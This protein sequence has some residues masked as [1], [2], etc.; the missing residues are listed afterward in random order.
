MKLLGWNCRGLGNPRAVRVLSDLLKARNPDFVFLSETISDA[1]RIENLRVKFGFS[2][3]FSVDRVGRSGGLAIFW[4]RHVDC[5]FLSY[6]Q[7]HVD[8]VFKIN[9]MHD[10]RMSCFYGFPERSRRSAS[11]DFIRMLANKSPLPWCIFGDF[12]DLLSVTD[13]EG[14]IPHPSSL[15]DGFR[16][17]IDDCSLTEL[18]LEGGKFTWE[19]GRGT[20]DWVRE[21]LDRAFA[22]YSWW[23]KF[24]LCNLSTWHVT[25]SDHD[26]IM[27]DLYNVPR[28]I[29]KFRFKFENVWLE[30]ASFRKEVTDYWLDLPPVHILPKL[31]SVSSFMAK[32]GKN[33]FHKFR[34]KVRKQKEELA[35]LVDRTDEM[36]VRQY[37]L[38]RD[39]L[40]ELLLN[41]EVYWKQRAKS[42]WL[43]EGDD[44]TKFFHAT[45]SARRKTN[46]ITH[47][48]TEDGQRVENQE[49]MCKIVHEYF[50]RIF[51][52]SQ[53]D[54]TG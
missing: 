24:P 5:E 54:D 50:T 3:C 17:V 33:F 36:G 7:N 2:Q 20:S 10:W 13:K 40:N 9:N 51:T 21:K 44:N 1:S 35:D 16:G 38:A 49:D 47:L 34:D 53:S 52:G 8:V 29:R 6:S 42:F 22:E 25:Y 23:Q 19:R 12:N 28:S 4:K 48:D 39:R 11:W 43:A 46:R 18:G 37:F 14:T 41:E 45:A 26:P 30:E 27:V 32:W 15:L 31:I